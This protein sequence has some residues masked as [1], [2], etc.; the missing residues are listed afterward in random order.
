[1][2]MSALIS[3][4]TLYNEDPT[5]FD[6]V[7]LPIAPVSDPEYNEYVQGFNMDK[8][9]LVNNLLIELAENSVLYTDPAFMKFAI[10]QWAAKEQHVWQQLYNTCFYRYNPI[11]NKDG[12][13]RDTLLETRNLLNSKTSSGT[14]T[15]TTE[16]DET[17]TEGVD[18]TATISRDNEHRVIYGHVIATATSEDDT[19]VG[20]ETDTKHTT[21][22]T[23]DETSLS[24][25]RPFDSTGLQD[26]FVPKEKNVT[27]KSLDITE[28]N[29]KTYSDDYVKST[30]G[31]G[32][33][34]HSGHDDTTILDDEQENRNTDSSRSTDATVEKTGSNS[35][36][37][38][39]SDTGTISHSDTHKE[40]GNIGVTMTQAMI[41][42]QRNIVK[43]NVYDYIIQSFKDRFC[44]LI[45]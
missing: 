11:W 43:F 18:E 1:M 24:Y 5:L 33:E 28:T 44:L 36:T 37:E 25:V 10:T 16:T 19:V 9:T 38:S 20:T 7:Q 3:I 13:I 34:S 4:L 22:A 35:L 42:E 30:A 12:T 14:N 45:Y 26:G 23:N 21:D 29:S 8:P 17:V 15:E 31:T 6:G 41:Q 32:R 39:G 2:P 27:E 40:Y